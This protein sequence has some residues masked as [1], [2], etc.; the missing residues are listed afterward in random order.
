MP[1]H[2]NQAQIY[3]QMQEKLL[4]S[5]VP[6]GLLSKY[7]SHKWF[8]CRKQGP[9]REEILRLGRSNNHLK[10]GKKKSSGEKTTIV[11]L[12]FNENLQFHFRWALVNWNQYKIW[13][14]LLSFA[15]I[16]VLWQIL[17]RCYFHYQKNIKRRASTLNCRT[18]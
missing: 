3:I 1:I 17:C 5:Y 14:L 15:L 11:L 6:T 4:Y 7:M 10:V 2:R 16:M 8:Y 9:H 18:Y 13:R 12:I